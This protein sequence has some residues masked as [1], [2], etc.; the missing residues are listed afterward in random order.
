[1]AKVLF[2]LT[3]RAAF[4]AAVPDQRRVDAFPSGELA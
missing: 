1:M 2:G 3:R 4:E